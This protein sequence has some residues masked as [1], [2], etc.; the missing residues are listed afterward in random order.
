VIKLKNNEGVNM[1]FVPYGQNKSKWYQL[2]PLSRPDWEELSYLH[3]SGEFSLYR[4]ESFDKHLKE[5][6]KL[7]KFYSH[8]NGK[9]L[10]AVIER[11][12]PWY[13]KAELVGLM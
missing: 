5:Y 8:L 6:D 2:K 11:E 7:N 10:K 9:R 12:R 1:R 3:G 13:G 4:D